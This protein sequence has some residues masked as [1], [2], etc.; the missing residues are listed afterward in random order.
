MSYVDDYMRISKQFLDLLKGTAL[1]KSLMDVLSTSNTPLVSANMPERDQDAIRPL[2]VVQRNEYETIFDADFS[3]VLIHTGAYANQLARNAG[4]LAVT[5]GNDIYF[6]D[7]QYAPESEEGKNLLAHELTHV[8]QHQKGDRMVYLEE[9]QEAEYQGSQAEAA[10]SGIGLHA[11]RNGELETEAGIGANAMAG[12]EALSIGG[13]RGGAGSQASAASL[14][15]FSAAG[16]G[17]MVEVQTRDGTKHLLHP[18][19]YQEVVE[20][21]KNGALELLREAQMLMTEAE[22]D[23]YALRWMQYWKGGRS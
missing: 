20:G 21:V 18:D 6:A 15:D 22:Y 7:G 1:K 17:V 3:G 16:G 8:T 14:G 12:G 11:A 9:I 19:E 23:A 5:I 2:D 10:V 4:A 13:A